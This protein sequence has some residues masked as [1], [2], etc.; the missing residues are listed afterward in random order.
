MAPPGASTVPSPRTVRVNENRACAGL[1]VGVND[2]VRGSYRSAVAPVLPPARSTLPSGSRADDPEFRS[3]LITFFTGTHRGPPVARAGVRPVRLLTPTITLSADP[4]VRIPRTRDTR[5]NLRTSFHTR[6]R[7]RE[8]PV[9][10]LLASAVFILLLPSPEDQLPDRTGGHLGGER[11]VGV[12][13][14]DSGLG[15]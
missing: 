12:G 9:W 3:V 15:G 11:P 8:E 13:L 5:L 4:T 6:G 1:P 7:R 2:L 10:A 14:D